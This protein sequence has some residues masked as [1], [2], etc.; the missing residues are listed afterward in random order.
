[1]L[2]RARRYLIQVLDALEPHIETETSVVV[3][4]PS[5]ASV[6]RD[7]ALNLLANDLKYGP[8][9][10]R[11]AAQTHTLSEFLIRKAPGYRPESLT[12]KHL[13]LHG[14]CH[15][16]PAM[17]QEL[18]WLRSCGA[19]VDMPDTGCCG[20]AGPFGFEKEKYG[21]SRTLANRV[22]MPAVEE[23]NS[24]TLIVTDGF[25]CREQIAQLGD[26]KAMHLAE[27]LVGHL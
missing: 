12:G 18:S 1:M 6:F 15:Q 13:L 22:L 24:E 19:T 10:K 26:R 25:S 17:N 7:E 11:L 5:C 21:I 8:R 4:E 14:H 16:K 2:D 9:A 3:L 27:V 20:M 23:A